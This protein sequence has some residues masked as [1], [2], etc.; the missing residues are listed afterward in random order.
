MMNSAA[1]AVDIRDL[2][3]RRGTT[4]V[5]HGL[6]LSI[7]RGGVVGLLGPSGSGK[8][9]LMRAIVGVQVVSSGTV[10][11][12][13]EP[14]GSVP[15]RH[16]VGYV[17]QS[18][19]VYDDLTVSQNI[20]YFSSVLGAPRS[21][22]ARVIDETDLAPFADRVVATLSGGQRSRVSLAAALLGAPELLVLDEPTVGLDPVLRVQLWELFHRLA[23]AGTTLLVSSHVMDEATR[24]DRLLLMRDGEMLADDTPQAL[25]GAT[26]ASD[27][28]GAFL[29]II[30]SRGDVGADAAPPPAH[31]GPGRRRHRRHARSEGER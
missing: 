20:A 12:L 9:T 8:T 18:A 6:D 13:G 10:T 2:Q 7:A 26:G 15:L 14:A 16:R 31:H 23:D 4:D 3:V 1:P 28:E 19:S 21:D 5:L 25:L 30:A 11:V 17:T 29:A 22:I 24:C 27:V